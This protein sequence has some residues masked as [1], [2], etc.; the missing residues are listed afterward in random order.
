ML[1]AAKDV[2]LYLTD[3]NLLYGFTP[4]ACSAAGGATAGEGML[5]IDE[6]ARVVERLK[7]T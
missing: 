1:G 2:D 6:T 3:A 7:G 4:A 5:E